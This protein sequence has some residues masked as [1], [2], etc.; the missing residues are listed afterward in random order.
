MKNDIFRRA[1]GRCAKIERQHC[2]TKKVEI[3]NYSEAQIMYIR[4]HPKIV[5]LS[6][7]KSEHRTLPL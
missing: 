5:N 7:K 1:N 3:N 4:M 2:I 6:K